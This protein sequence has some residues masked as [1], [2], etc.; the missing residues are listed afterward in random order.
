MVG[1]PCVAIFSARNAPGQWE[2]LGEHHVVIED[3][4]ACAGCMLDECVD[5]QKKCL[6]RI[7]TGRVLREAISLI[8]SRRTCLAH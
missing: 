1:I 4:P 5:Q 6:T 3:R 8:E 7:E 2:P